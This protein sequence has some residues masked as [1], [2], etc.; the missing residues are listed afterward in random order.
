MITLSFERL[1]FLR[2]ER[3]LKQQE[4]ADVL[5]VKQVNISNWENTK[6]IIPLDKLN[7]YANYFKVSLDYITGLS[8][9]KVKTRNIKLNKEKIGDN[10]K[11]LRK[12]FHL[13]QQDL[14]N[15][16][17]TSHS[18]ISAYESGKTMLLTAFAYQICEKYN[19]SFDWLV[20][21]SNNKYLKQKSL[22]A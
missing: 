10:L 16:L 19:I 17:N 18:T 7:F 20:G 6:E 11:L 5:G 12:E 22:S 8:D 1:F 4:L 9:E 21:R 15:V 3:D 2:E 14:A 13:T